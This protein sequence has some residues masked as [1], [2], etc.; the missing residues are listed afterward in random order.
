[1]PLCSPLT[2]SAEGRDLA[3]HFNCKFIETS[4]KNRIHVDDAFWELV[5]EIRR[6]NKV[7]LDLVLNVNSLQCLTVV[8]R[9]RRSAVWTL[10]H[11][12]APAAVPVDTVT[13]LA[14]PM[15]RVPAAV[16]AVS[17]FNERT[18]DACLAFPPSYLL[19]PPIPSV[20]CF[21][22][23]SPCYESLMNMPDVLLHSR[24]ISSRCCMCQSLLHRPHTRATSQSCGFRCVQGRCINQCCS[25]LRCIQ[26]HLFRCVFSVGHGLNRCAP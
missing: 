9:S 19:S 4:A 10:V 5:R 6:H 20:R 23:G 3:K 12:R 17:S 26:R 14:R 22:W 24:V 16:A 25:R 7:R 13:T 8:I 21:V 15:K 1:M 2:V 11:P 18:H